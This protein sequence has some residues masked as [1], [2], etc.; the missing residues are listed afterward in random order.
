MKNEVLIKALEE[1]KAGNWEEAHRL[2]QTREDPEF[3]W[4]HA[5]LHRKERDPGN[6]A[7]WYS[8]AGQP[9]AEDSLEEEWDRLYHALS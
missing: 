5:Y 1:D 4:V 8:R 3:A 9:V 7:Y 6:A 2:A